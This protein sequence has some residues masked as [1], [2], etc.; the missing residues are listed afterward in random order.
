MTLTPLTESNIES[1][2]Y[3]NIFHF[4]NDRSYVI[5][6]RFRSSG[7]KFVYDSDPYTKSINFNS[8]PYLIQGMPL[9]TQSNPSANGKS[10]DLT[11]SLNIIVRTAR[12]GA[13][14]S[15]EGLGRQDMFTIS[16]SIIKTFNSASVKSLLRQN[17]M[18]NINIE[19]INVDNYEL[20]EKPIF[21]SEFLLTFSMRFKISS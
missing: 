8:F 9:H 7:S 17:N 16:D 19:K 3:N 2:A 10:K 15:N 20:D 14:N 6:P 11:Y 12:S 21:E 4:L 13:G 18:F 5:D 1:I